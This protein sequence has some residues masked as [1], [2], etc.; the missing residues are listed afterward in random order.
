MFSPLV[1][2]TERSVRMEKPCTCSSGDDHERTCEVFLNQ[3]FQIREAVGKVWVA[4]EPLSEQQKDCVLQAV[5]ILMG[6]AL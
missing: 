2:G 3:A 5:R 1:E 6:L 4:L